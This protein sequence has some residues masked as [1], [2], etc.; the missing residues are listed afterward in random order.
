MIKGIKNVTIFARLQGAEVNADGE[1]YIII[2]KDSKE[3]SETTVRKLR[4][5]SGT[6]V[7]IIV[8]SKGE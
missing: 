2:T 7:T 8:S 1:I 5:L 6:S 4:E 3:S